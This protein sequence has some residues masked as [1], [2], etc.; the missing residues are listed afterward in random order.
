MASKIIIMFLFFVMALPT[1]AQ[2]GGSMM[3]GMHQDGCMMCAAG[4]VLGGLLIIA[5]IVLLVSLSIFL[6]R[7]SKTSKP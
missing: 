7:R 2:E 4:M 3:H 1:K 6:I 5:I